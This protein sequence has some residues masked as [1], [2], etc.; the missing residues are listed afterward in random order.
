M[1]GQSII[2][3]YLFLTGDNV[4]DLVA[5]ELGL[6]NKGK[7]FENDDYY[8]FV[9]PR[10]ERRSKRA[11]HDTTASLSQHE[12]VSWAEQ[13][14][15]QYRVKRD[16]ID[17]REDEDRIYRSISFSDPK[18]DKEWYLKDTR[19]KSSL[20]LPKLDLHVVP[21]WAADPKASWDLNDNDD[22]PSPRYDPT[23]E[24]KHG[25]R[26]AGE[27]AMMA[28][29]SIC[30]V[31]IAYNAKIG[32]IRMLDGHVTDRVEAEAIAFNH[33]YIDI[34]SAS[35]GPNDDG[36]T[37]EGPGTLA[38][39]AF[40]KG[41]T[42]GR[43][44][45][46]V[47]YVWASGNGGRRQDNCN[48]DGYTGSIYTISISSASEHQQSPWYAEKCPSTM[49]TT[50]SSGAYQDQKVTTTDLHNRCTDDHTGTSASAP[51]AAGIFALVLEANSELT[52]RDLQHL[53]AWTS[54]YAPLSH[55]HG[56]TTNGAGFKANSRF[57]FG[58]L[59]AAA[60][61]Q[62]AKDWVTVPKQSICEIE[63]IKFER[64][65]ISPERPLEIDF[66]VT[67]CEGEN[68]VVR[69]LEHVQLYVT[70]TYNRRG[71]LKINITSP[72]GTETTLLAEREQDS[73]SEGFKNWAFMS[74]H[75][76]GENPKGVWKIEIIDATGNKNNHGEL[77]D[78]RLV[79]HGTAD[80]PRHLK[81]GPRV[82]DE[83]YNTVHNERSE[84]LTNQLNSQEKHQMNVESPVKR[85]RE[86]EQPVQS[87]NHWL[88]VL[89]RLNGNWLQ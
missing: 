77:Q 52:W 35:W 57:G 6:K 11:A 69:F 88:K 48:C 9:H 40:I 75:N 67:G 47:I 46:G 23:N 85:Y 32:G 36:R 17:K 8:L 13:Q 30:G 5:S 4:A 22:D 41:I 15:S 70:L 14:K 33:K 63:P 42:E 59:N 26:C 3:D 73:S 71:A 55:N 61:V 50:Y 43:N 65:K 83:N 54:E 2:N 19:S 51:L 7:I 25:T 58:L 82:Y 28:N 34:Y 79:L 39:A 66:P 86:Q 89:A 72:H 44:G 12:K 80:I 62:A 78:F 53:V 64:Q 10:I 56:W 87:N 1:S 24:N 38:S 20:D 60:L 76:W 27:V 16:L 84:R 31:G 45:K 21:A 81:N 74:V 29:N 37:V 18:F 68:N 49:A